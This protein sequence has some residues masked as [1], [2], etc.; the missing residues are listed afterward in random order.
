[1]SISLKKGERKNHTLRENGTLWEREIDGERFVYKWCTTCQ[2][3]RPPR[4]SHCQYCDNC[5]RE[6]DHHCPFVANCIGERNY[7]SFMLFN[8]SIVA[9]L[10]SVIASVFSALNAGEE[11]PS[12]MVT[13]IGIVA[14]CVFSLIMFCVMFSFFGFHCWLIITGQT[15]KEQ[16]KQWRSKE[17]A[18]GDEHP[19]EGGSVFG[20]GRT[21]AC[22]HRAPSLIRPRYLVDPVLANAQSMSASPSNTHEGDDEKG[23]PVRRSSGSGSRS[24]LHESD[25]HPK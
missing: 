18:G 3:W 13:I 2:I 8:L 22:L 23:A 11:G 20:P 10:V 9:L 16:M 15:T 1:V 17:R 12:Q 24:R 5:V 19:L 6:F 14:V 21:L 25:F 4:A 7:G